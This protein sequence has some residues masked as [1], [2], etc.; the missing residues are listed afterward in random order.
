MRGA[1]KPQLLRGRPKGHEFAAQRLREARHQCVPQSGGGRQN[2]SA[3]RGTAMVIQRQAK[4]QF[5]QHFGGR[6]DATRSPALRFAPSSALEK[7][8]LHR[9][10]NTEKF[11]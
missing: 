6:P 9:L 2:A 8:G 1:K 10:P 4:S 11:L 3:M 7:W 5:G